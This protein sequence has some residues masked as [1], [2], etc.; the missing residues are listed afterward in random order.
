MIKH[1]ILE[2]FLDVDEFTK[3]I[4]I[5]YGSAPFDGIKVFNNSFDREGNTKC[6]LI[7][8]KPLIELEG[9]S[10]FS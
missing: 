1:K 6:S 3:L 2:N 10:I 7:K 8:K 5:N 4:N 9:L